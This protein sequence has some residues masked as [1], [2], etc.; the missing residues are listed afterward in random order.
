MKELKRFLNKKTLALF[1]VAALACAPVN[2][3]TSQAEPYQGGFTD[4]SEYP[5]LTYAE[6]VYQNVTVDA[7]GIASRVTDPAQQN[8]VVEQVKR[9][10]D[11]SVKAYYTNDYFVNF[12]KHIEYI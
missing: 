3:I 9:L 7:G 10:N 1:L 12:V 5:N 11:A 4:T 6:C 2:A 8:L